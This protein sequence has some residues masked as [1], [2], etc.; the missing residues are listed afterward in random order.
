VANYPDYALL[1]AWNHAAEIREKEAKFIA[2]G[3]QWIVYVPKV[4]IVT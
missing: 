1:F 4:E 3:G 2:A